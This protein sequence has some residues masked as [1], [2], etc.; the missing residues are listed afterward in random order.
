MKKEQLLEAIGEVDEQLLLQSEQV[1]HTGKKTI[2]RLLL[3]AAAVGLLAITA[4]AGVGLMSRPIGETEIILGETIAPFYMDA[5]GNIIP[6]GVEGIKI[7]MEVA[8]DAEV[9]TYLEEI[10]HLDMSEEWEWSGG[11]GGM[12]LYTYFS[13]SKCWEQEGKPGEVRLH[14]NVV[15]ATQKI[16]TVDLLEKLTVEAELL[17][18]RKTNMAGIEVLKVV[19]PAQPNYKGTKYCPEGETRLYWCDG[20][21]L[22]QLDYPSWI[23][24]AEAEKLLKAMEK[25]EYIVPLPE[26]YGTVNT[27]RISQLSPQFSVQKGQTGTAM[28]NSVMGWGR[29]AYSDNVIYYGNDGKI[30]G[31]DLQTQKSTIYQLPNRLSSTLELFATENYVCYEDMRDALMA[32]PKTGGEPVVIYQGL[33]VTHLY[34]DGPELYS[35]NGGNYL[36]RINLETGKV[37]RLVDN[38]N[39]YYV[40]DTYIY[41][42]QSN[43]EGNYFLRSRKDTIRFEKIPLS[44]YPI[45]VVADGEDLY[46]CRGG[47][48]Y[49]YRVIHYRDGVEKELPVYAYDYQLMDGKLLYH[50][51]HEE[52]MIRSYDLKTGEIAVLQ[53]RCHDF[54]I[55]EDRY[56]GFTCVDDENHP[57]P[58]IL[59]TKTGESYKPKL[60]D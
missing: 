57:Y 59:D 33:G 24:D 51:D 38:A 28:A 4:A 5:Q 25:E 10:Y 58:V 11:G 50:D 20:Q 17:T 6:S 27:E 34:A 26:D 39:S 7:A 16:Q 43:A 32:Q 54:A 31:F 52:W 40:D 42:V 2:R 13:W 60:T 35:N 19:I 15:D 56:I 29:F 49:D 47:K 14:Q 48:G 22:L 45:K 23:S 18:A 21:Y 53:E 46:F 36:S 3:V 44:F 37:E 30:I 55:M 12:G 9:P 41:V 8:V 1:C